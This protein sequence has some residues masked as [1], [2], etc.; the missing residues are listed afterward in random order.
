MTGSGRRINSDLDIVFY[1]RVGLDTTHK[2]VENRRFL[3]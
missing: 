3:W 1:T 2:F